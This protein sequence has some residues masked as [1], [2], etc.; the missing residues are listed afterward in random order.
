VLTA[1]CAVAPADEFVD[2]RRERVLESTDEDEVS[3]PTGV[4]AIASRYA[5]RWTDSDGVVVMLL[6]GDCRVTQGRRT[7]TSN[8]MVIW[9]KQDET[10]PDA[11]LVVYMEGEATLTEPGLQRQEPNQ[12]VQLSTKAG[13][14]MGLEPAELTGANDP[15]YVRGLQQ[16]NALLH[17]SV[18][19]TRLVAQSGPSLP[20]P[21]GGMPQPGLPR[22]H[23]T[24]NPRYIAQEPAINGS[25]YEGVTPAEYVITITRG[26]NIV[27]DNVPLEVNGQ[28]I[29]SRLDLTAD[30]AVIWTD[31][32][33]VNSPSNFEVNENTPLQIYLEGSIVVLQGQNVATATHAFYDINNKRGLFLNAEVRTFIPDLDGPL[34]LRA[35]SI[36][37][38]SENNFH[39]KNAFVT[40]STF[41]RPGYRLE[42]NDIYLEERFDPSRVDPATGGPVAAEP[43]ITAIG[44]R[45]YIEEVPILPLP[46]ISTTARNIEAPFQKFE[47]GY[48]GMFGAMIQTGF[49]L[50]TLFGLNLPDGVN[51]S[52]GFNYFSKRGPGASL[53]STYDTFGDF[54]GLP[55]RYSGLANFDYINDHGDDRLGYGRRNLNVP[56]DNRGRALW[57]NRMDFS[58]DT[59]LT[60]ELGYLSDRNYLEQYYESSWDRDKDYETGLFL[61]HQQDNVEINGVVRDRINSFSD[62]TNWLPRFDL[63]VLGEPLL[64]SLLSWS[65]RSSVGYGQIKTAQAPSDPT[66]PF[67][68]LNYLQNASGLVAMT[69]H[70]LDMPFMLGPVNVTPY[71]LGEAAAWQEDNNG[72]D[73]GRLYGSAGVRAKLQFFKALPDFYDPVFGLNG[74]AHKMQFDVDY[75]IAKSSQSLSN[76]PQ[77]NEFDDDAQERFQER[78]VPIEF[79]GVLP[80]QFDPR[81]Y[82][83]RSGAGRD[84][85]DPYFELVDDMHVVRLGWRNRWQTKD[86]PP[87]RQRIRDWMTLDLEASIFPNANRDNFGETFGLL[88]GRYAWHVGQRTSI[89]ANA[90]A[91]TFED[92]Q[93]IWN[94]GLLTQ[95]GARGSFYFGV[96]QVDVGPISSRLL[97]GS[98]SYKMS[99]KWVSTVAAAYDVAEHRDRGESLTITRIGE[100]MLLH[101]GV[102]FDVSRNNVGVGISLEPRLGPMNSASNQMSS[103][104]GI[105]R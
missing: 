89:L 87:D 43:W 6:R 27:V 59:W 33:A 2:A 86:G 77:Y 55:T 12:I 64:G 105:S 49:D 21:N 28:I 62:Q 16:R 103:L 47:V 104:L 76:V 96:R 24:I 56:N 84:V 17:V 15:V 81:Y 79:G 98:Y 23:L 70:E 41:G 71:V 74:L 18:A 91:D 80:A 37:Q 93:R 78:Y 39:A 44:N 97:T 26:V 1:L 95:R 88:T 68:P 7:L 46:P 8:E 60:A 73:L 40:T 72:N 69:R 83:V 32:N 42:S 20:S 94:V 9:G 19:K 13:V 45:F 61:N 65:S 31:G 29:L 36:R 82:A 38:L 30:R 100:Y 34:R 101:L 11:D 51:L 35:D 63:S 14:K 3:T 92:G 22:R 66:D 54:L 52:G 90:I 99:P 75:Y 50:N 48:S 85:T 10:H 102:G 5:T 67:Q 25:L 4:I 53:N 57:R 58:P